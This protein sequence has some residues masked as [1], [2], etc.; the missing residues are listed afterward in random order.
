MTAAIR[1]GCLFFLSLVLC[2]GNLF[3]ADTD[4][5]QSLILLGL[6]ENLGLRAD[7]FSVS[8]AREDVKVAAGVFDSE[9]YAN[10]EVQKQK[11]PN[12]S[13]LLPEENFDQQAF[14]TEVG[15]RKRFAVG[16]EGT[17]FVN[18]ARI[19]DSSV[20][21]A[22]DPKYQSTIG[23]ELRQPLLRDAGAGVNQLELNLARKTSSRADLDF[24]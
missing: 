14:S 9:F 23:L 5:L 12:S 16:L 22:L 11:I 21:E 10:T 24:L 1:L 2:S 3:A 6:K 13:S 8:T 7:R 4:R 17:F 20:T 18:S 19:E 15:L